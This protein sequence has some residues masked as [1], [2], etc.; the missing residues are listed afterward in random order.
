MG[1]IGL[2]KGSIDY[3]EIPQSFAEVAIDKMKEHYINNGV[4]IAE[5]IPHYTWPLSDDAKKE[6]WKRAGFE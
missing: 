2:D 5:T 6:K 1:N 4:P 3:G